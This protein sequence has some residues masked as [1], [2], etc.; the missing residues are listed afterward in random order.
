MKNKFFGS[1]PALITPF[2]EEKKIDKDAFQKFVNWQINEGS[3]VLVPVGTT[4]ESPTLSHE[5]H[6]E[7]IKLCV[8]AAQK[9]VPIIAG[10]G[11]NATDEAVYLGQQAEKCGVDALL[12]VTPYYNKPSQTGLYLHYKEIASNVSLPIII[13]NIPG[14]SVIDMSMDTMKRL[15]DECDNI[16][17]VKDA[18][19]DVTRAS[20]AR[21][22]CGD[23]FILLSGEDASVSGFLGQGGH[24][25]ISVAANVAPKLSSKM[26]AAWRDG[27]YQ[28][29]AQ[30][31]DM[32]FPL[33]RALF[34]ENSP[35]PTKYALSLLGKCKNITRLPVA[36]I[37]DQSKKIVEKAM[38]H[39]KLL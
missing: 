1:I 26:H 11:S 35:A 18:T 8:E 5:E 19:N 14:R 3:N 27:N 4:G 32:L 7:V 30:Y 39:A 25:C 20:E 16:I 36:P 31:R 10:A 15:Y 29:F 28:D 6:I 12:V 38:E 37:S 24:G 21:I 17:G 22:A 2:N 33:S 34:C 9:R 13:Y 23:D